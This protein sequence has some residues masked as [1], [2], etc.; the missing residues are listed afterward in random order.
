MDELSRQEPEAISTAM[1]EYMATKKG[2]FALGGNY[3]G[4][5]LP[6]PDFVDGPDAE[7]TLKAVLDGLDKVATTG[8]FAPYHAEF[9][10][11]LLGKRTEGTG[12]LFTYAA[13]GMQKDFIPEGAGADIVH[14]ASSSGNFFTICAALLFRFLGAAHITSSNP[15][16]KPTIDPRYLSHPLD[17][18]VIARFI[19]YI[20]TIVRADPLAKL[21]LP[22]GRRSHGAPT[23]LT[24]LE[25]AKAYAKQATLSYWHLTSTCAMLPRERGGVVDPSL[26]VYGVEG[27]RIVDASVFPVATRGNSQTTVYA[28]AERAADLIK[29]SA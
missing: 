6:V 16:E 24:D 18:E 2:P 9:V 1:Q 11:S 15:A 22:G 26:L 28:V 17:L 23:D 25:Q 14:K 4:S 21:L 12:N 7:A 13:C 19:R 29:G 27:L 10:H 5:L 3:A 8:D 20:G